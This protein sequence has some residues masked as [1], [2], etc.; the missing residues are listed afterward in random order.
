M[1]K[2]Y[3]YLD[4]AEEVLG[5]FPL[6]E[7]D[8]LHKSGKI[9]AVTKICEEGTQNW[10][11]FYEIPRPAAPKQK[12][13][14]AAEMPKASQAKQVTERKP[15]KYQGVTRNQGA[16]LIA[17]LLVGIGAPFLVFLKPVPQWEYEV[18]SGS[19]GNFLAEMNKHGSEGWELVTSRPVEDGFEGIVK[20]P[21]R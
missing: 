20:R 16:A 4:A 15:P 21:K 19:Y 8:A 3:Y 9:T 18:V 17:I 7:L 12:L 5:P 2:K 10:M 6:V 13:P 1:S 11:P 14:E